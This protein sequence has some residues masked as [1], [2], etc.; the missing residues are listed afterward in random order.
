MSESVFGVYLRGETHDTVVSPSMM[1]TILSSADASSVPALDQALQN[2]FGDR[3]LV[4]NLQL[5]RNREISDDVSGIMN[6][7]PFISDASAGI[8]RLVQ[9]NTPGLVTFSRSPVDQFTWERESHVSMSEEN[10]STCEANLFSLVRSFVGQN[11]STLLMGETF[12]E[13]FP[14]F[15]SDLWTL[16]NNFVPL[17]IGL[18]RWVPTTPNISAGFPARSRLLHIMS[19]FYR[20]FGAWDDG[21]DPGFE[22]RELDD[23]SDLVKQRMRIFRKMELSPGASAAGNLSLYWDVIEYTTKL[24]FWTIIHILADSELLKEIRKEISSCVKS[25]RPSLQ[26]TGF[27]FDEPPRLGLDLEKVLT[28]CPLLRACYYESIRVHSAG[29]SFRKLESD[30]TVTES[31]EDAA[32]PRTYKFRKGAK[33]IMPHGVSY[34]DPQR[35]SNP[36]QY[37]P[38]RFIVTDPVSGTQQA[39]A[40]SL[41]PFADGLYGSKNNALTERAILAFTAGIVSMWDIT[42]AN[43]SGLAVPKNWKTWGTYQ[44]ARDVRVKLKLRV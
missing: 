35:F 6:R 34:N 4:R 44:P 38:L 9:R 25:S 3:S 29:I 17:F 16:D 41:G 33:V 37:D 7:E 42:S 10:Q 1:K 13:N 20:A 39:S 31:A 36:D 14:T 27:P 12:V 24:T 26:E 21:I 11:M 30:M 5:P 32:Q 19:V 2:V 23:V 28:A 40:A 22:L 8:V 43:E 18:R 15:L